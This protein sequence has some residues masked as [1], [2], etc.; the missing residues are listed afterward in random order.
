[1]KVQA[2]RR[3]FNRT[4]RTLD[5]STQTVREALIVDLENAF[6]F[7]IN[8]MRATQ[9]EKNKQFWA[10][11]IAYTAQTIATV[12]REYDLGRIDDKLTELE[13]R[14]QKIKSKMAK[15][16]EDGKTKENGYVY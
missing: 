6:E 11:I 3:N 7:A 1:M 10:R 9:K 2:A 16:V 12:A 5:V 14:F 13:N 4:R 8:R 15:R